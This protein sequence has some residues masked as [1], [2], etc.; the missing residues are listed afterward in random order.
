MNGDD[1]TPQEQSMH[2]SERIAGLVEHVNQGHGAALIEQLLHRMELTVRDFVS[3][4][5]QLV[6]RLKQS[7]ETQEALLG[8]IKRKYDFSGPPGLT[9]PE[10]SEEEVPEWER[11][12]ADLEGSTK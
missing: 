7:A 1:P 10:I 8:R 4:A 12:L 9:P 11:R 5:D 6:E 3:E 2:L